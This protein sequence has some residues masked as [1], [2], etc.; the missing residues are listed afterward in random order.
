MYIMNYCIE[1]KFDG[2]LNLTV[3]DARIK[4]NPVNINIAINILTSTKFLRSSYLLCHH[5]KHSVQGTSNLPCGE[6]EE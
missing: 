6:S 5:E 1:G 2:G 4:L 3:D